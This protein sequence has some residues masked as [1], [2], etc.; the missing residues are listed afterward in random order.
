MQQN[1]LQRFNSLGLAN[2]S[3]SRPGLLATILQLQGRGLRWLQPE[4]AGVSLRQLLLLTSRL[5]QEES[6]GPPDS[7]DSV[8]LLAPE[9]L[10]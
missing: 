5:Q 3:N 1:R 7:L 8:E 4:Q 10:V 2:V 6:H 9:A